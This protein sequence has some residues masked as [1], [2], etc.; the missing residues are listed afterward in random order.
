MAEAGGLA[1]HSRRNDRFSRPPR[2]LDRFSFRGAPGRT[3]TDNPRL[4]TAPLSILSYWSIDI[5]C[6]AWTRTKTWCLTGTRATLT[7]LGREMVGRLG[8]APSVSW[9][10]TRRIAVFLAPDKIGGATASRAPTCSMPLNRSP[11]ER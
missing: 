7:R 1:P 6:R 5:G 2:C 10:Q 4:R 8:A 3:L 9:S 11:V